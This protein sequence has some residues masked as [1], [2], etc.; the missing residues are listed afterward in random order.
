MLKALADPV[1]LKIML[2][3][4]G[5]RRTVGEVASFFH[6]TQPTISRHL[7]ALAVAGVVRREKVAQQV[8]Y[9]I[10]TETMGMVCVQ[11]AAC[12]PCCCLEVK[13]VT[14]IDSGTVKAESPGTKSTQKPRSRKSK[15]GVL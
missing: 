8:Y 15:G 11:L 12:F 13:S 4:E 14:P 2:M 5:H 1:R 7:Q 10:N 9:A 6:L 3:L